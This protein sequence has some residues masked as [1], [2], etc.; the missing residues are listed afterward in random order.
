MRGDVLGHRHNNL[1][2]LLLLLLMMLHGRRINGRKLC[3]RLLVVAWLLLLLALHEAGIGDAR[4]G[5]R[6]VAAI[7]VV[8]ASHL[9]RLAHAGG[10]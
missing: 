6:V 2:L 9:V 5:H 8:W 4:T 10:H 1:R 7:V 3:L